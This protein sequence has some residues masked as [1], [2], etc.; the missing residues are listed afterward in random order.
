MVLTWKEFVWS[1]R[2]FLIILI[3]PYE[4]YQWQQFC[5]PLYNIC[6][7]ISKA[8]AL[9]PFYTIFVLQDFS[10]LSKSSK[11]IWLTIVK[12]WLKIDK[13]KLLDELLSGWC[14]WLEGFWYSKISS[15]KILNILS[16]F[17]LKNKVCLVT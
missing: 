2:E 13:K 1:D 12:D 6:V 8:T 10:S 14:S 15:W 4:K 17:C 7:T 11:K 5:L 16:F 3:C 9:P